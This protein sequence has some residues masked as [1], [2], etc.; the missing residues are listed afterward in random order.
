MQ[1]EEINYE[2]ATEAGGRFSANVDDSSDPPNP[3]SNNHSGSLLPYHQPEAHNHD[4]TIILGSGSVMVDYMLSNPP[5]DLINNGI[6]SRIA[7]HS[8]QQQKRQRQQQ[9]QHQQPLLLDQPNSSI[10]CV[11]GGIPIN[12][13][14]TLSFADVMQFADFGPKLALNHPQ[15]LQHQENSNADQEDDHTIT[16]IDPV[17]FL[18]FPVLSNSHMVPGH[19]NTSSIHDDSNT[20]TNNSIN[21]RDGGFGDPL[22]DFR[23]REYGYDHQ[24]EDAAAAAATAG[25]LSTSANNLSN[26]VQLEFLGNATNDDNNLMEGAAAGGTMGHINKSSSSSSKRKRPRSIKTNEEVE[27]Q[28]MTHIAVE[29]NRRKQMNEHLR[30]LRSLMPSSYVQRGDQASII[31][32]AIEFVR[33]LEQLLQCLE[34]QKRRRLYGDQPRPMGDSSTSS[35]STALGLVQQTPQVQPPLGFPPPMGSQ[36]HHQDDDQLRL[37]DHQLDPMAMPTPTLC[38]QLRED[39]SAKRLLRARLALQT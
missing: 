19:G 24:Q 27:S 33:E 20:P 38:L 4:N 25:V 15:R 29:R 32:G 21:D 18:K 23:D 13:D 31:G 1:R 36:Y 22:E 30:V 34:S 6:P 28:R 5:P 17:Y 3:T 11:S 7:Y 2:A 9:H 16:A 12:M 39:C 37:L 10:N 14:R 8:E 35:S 26:P